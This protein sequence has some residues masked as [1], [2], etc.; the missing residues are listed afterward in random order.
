[1][2]PFV[3]RAGT[4][5]FDITDQRVVFIQFRGNHGLGTGKEGLVPQI[6]G[7]GGNVP[8]ETLQQFALIGAV[9]R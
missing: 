1:M 4:H 8:V 7:Q 5:I 2:V 9:E 3:E 6:I